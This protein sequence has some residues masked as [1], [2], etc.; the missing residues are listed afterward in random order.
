MLE[1]VG[2]SNSGSGKTIMGLVDPHQNFVLR[3][4]PFTFL[5]NHGQ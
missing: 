3:E 4:N 2:A 5:E 1:N